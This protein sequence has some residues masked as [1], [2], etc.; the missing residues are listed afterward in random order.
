M[1]GPSSDSFVNMETGQS[2]PAP[3]APVYHVGET[4]ALIEVASIL[5]IGTTSYTIGLD[6]DFEASK[7]NYSL[8]VG[9]VSLLACLATRAASLGDNPILPKFMTLWWLAGTGFMTFYGPYNNACTG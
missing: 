1:S 2:T 4:L 6:F 5:I 8:A 9:V 3:K 7:L